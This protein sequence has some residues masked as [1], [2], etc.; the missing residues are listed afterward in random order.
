M[1]IF[2]ETKLGSLLDTLRS[3]ARAEIQDA[4][5]N[6]LLSVEENQLIEE[7]CG[8][9]RL[10][11]PGIRWEQAVVAQREEPIPYGRLPIGMQTEQVRVA[12]A[13][14]HVLTY[15]VPFE[16]NGDLFHFRPVGGLIWTYEVRVQSG[17]LTFD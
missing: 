9:Y 14:K 17:M 4:D 13:F 7:V 1:K 11:G 6:E 10:K 12:S 8:R 3:R 15:K 5:A 16:G 2:S